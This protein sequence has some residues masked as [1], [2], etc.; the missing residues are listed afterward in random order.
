MAVDGAFGDLRR[1]ADW[2]STSP[3]CP[4]RTSVQIERITRRLG[5]TAIPLLGRELASPDVRRRDAARDALAALATGAARPRVVASLRLLLDHPTGIADELK[6]CVLGLLSELGEHAEARF[7]DPRA[8]QQRSA[9]ALA[10]QLDTALDLANAAD[11]MVRRLPDDDIA[12]MIELLVVS[13]PDAA[14]RLAGELGVRLDL[15]ADLRERIAA[16]VSGI[17]PA[18]R[19]TARRSPRPTHAAVLVDAAARLVVVATRKISGERRWRRWAVLVSARGHI[20]DCIHEDDASVDGD[21]APLIANLVADGYRVASNDVDHA[22]TVVATAA[23]ITASTPHLL[24]SAYYLGRDLLDLDDAHLGPRAHRD[25]E[26]RTLGRAVDLLAGGD[27]AR[28]AQL[29]ERCD[30]SD[31]QVAAAVAACALAQGNP[32]EA[33]EPLGRAIASEPTWPLHHWN[34][35]VALRALGDTAGCYHALRR[36]VATS[37]APSGLYGDPDQPGRVACAE[38]MLAD[39]Q[40]AARL[41]GV[42]LAGRRRRN[43]RTA[44]RRS[45]LS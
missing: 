2:F 19:T 21:A 5:T 4:R 9:L 30:A 16:C 37:A 44:K 8:M 38:R 7:A 15:A 31:P 17:A 27:P 26:A 12:Q 39:L 36:F 25:P 11:L 3:T 18:A 40:R 20:D 34:L 24:S 33:I 13:A 22:R 10:A 23:R 32:C 29:L 42:S 45:E 35:A 1:L 6:V 41:A 14:L 43:R 28:A